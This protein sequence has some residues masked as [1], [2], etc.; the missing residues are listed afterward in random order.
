MGFISNLYDDFTDAVGHGIYHSMKLVGYTDDEIAG[1]SPTSPAYFHAMADRADRVGQLYEE[2]NILGGFVEANVGTVSETVPVA[3]VTTSEVLGEGIYHGMRAVGYTDEE[4]AGT[5]ETSPRL[6]H[7][8]ADVGDETLEM[9]RDGDAIGG[10]IHANAGAVRVG[11]EEGVVAVKDAFNDSV[12]NGI[13]NNLLA[14]A[15]GGLGGW[16]LGGIAGKIFGHSILGPF[17]GMGG[18]IGGIAGVG[19]GAAGGWFLG[20]QIMGSLGWSLE[21]ESDDEVSDTHDAETDRITRPVADTAIETDVR[22]RD[23]FN[24]VSPPETADEPAP[25]DDTIGER[26]LA[27]A[28]P[29][30]PATGM[31]A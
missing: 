11:A 16:M 19:L 26:T 30:V 23:N 6:F 24:L 15:I 13:W 5:A 20:D 2:G 3:L 21:S 22:T 14:T 12:H 17:G 28:A 25:E 1:T 31:A 7:R 29:Q 4:I 10:M 9:Y 18:D 27:F 8:L